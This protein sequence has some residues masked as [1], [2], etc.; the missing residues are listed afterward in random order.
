MAQVMS[1]VL[2]FHAAR[3]TTVLDKIMGFWQNLGRIGPLEVMYFHP[4]LKAQLT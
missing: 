1:T 2:K 3:I 4:P